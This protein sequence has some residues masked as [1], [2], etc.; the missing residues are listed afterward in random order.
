MDQSISFCVIRSFFIHFILLMPMALI[1]CQWKFFSK[2]KTLAS[3]HDI[4]SCVFAV[5][6]K[7]SIVPIFWCKT[8]YMLQ[9][10]YS[11]CWIGCWVFYLCWKWWGGVFA[12]QYEFSWF[13]LAKWFIIYLVI[14]FVGLWSCLS[15]MWMFQCSTCILLSLAKNCFN[16]RMRFLF[17]DTF[18]YMVFVLLVPFVLIG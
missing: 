13:I 10:V 8:A 6:P 18:L 14:C 15:W 16:L 12:N 5:V 2:F 11:C 3:C 9:Y 7:K 17:S 1:C 4:S